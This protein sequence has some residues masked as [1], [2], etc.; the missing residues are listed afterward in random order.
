[1]SSVKT[2]DGKGKKLKIRCLYKR[3]SL[4]GSKYVLW[5]VHSN[6]KNKFTWVKIIKACN[7]T[8]IH[9]VTL[10]LLAAYFTKTWKTQ[11]SFS[12]SFTSELSMIRFA[13][14][15][16]RF[17]FPKLSSVLQLRGNGSRSSKLLCL[18]K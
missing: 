6:C 11:N 13:I 5:R 14:E 4:K 15:P 17:Y 10:P 16:S 18:Y 9:G 7:G 12:S 8:T 2:C 1:M 3:R